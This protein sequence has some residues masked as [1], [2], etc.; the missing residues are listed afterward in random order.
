MLSDRRI[1]LYDRSELHLL[2]GPFLA[3]QWNPDPK[4]TDFDFGVAGG[5]QLDTRLYGGLGLSVG[6]LYT[7]GFKDTTHSVVDHW[8]GWYYTHSRTLSIR[9]GLSVHTI[10]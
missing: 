4:A 10:D 9:A 3:Y 8:K 6:A 1:E 5:A 2:V 7:H